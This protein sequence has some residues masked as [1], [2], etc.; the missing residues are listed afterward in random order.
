LRTRF[1]CITRARRGASAGV[2]ASARSPETR[3]LFGPCQ[4]RLTP[5][6]GGA[7]EQTHVRAGRGHRLRVDRALCGAAAPDRFA[8]SLKQ[9][10]GV[11]R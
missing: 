10:P 3:A 7:V 11:S 6:A 1:R 5:V 8:A 4:G 2:G 9:A